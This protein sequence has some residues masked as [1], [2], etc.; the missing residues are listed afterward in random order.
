MTE[1][2]KPSGA[3]PEDDTDAILAELEAE[4]DDTSSTAYQQRLNELQAEA[5]KGS[6]N[7]SF[8]LPETSARQDS[9]LN[10]RSDDETLRFT[11]EHEK[12][13]VHFRHPDFARCSIMDEHLDKIAQRH[14]VGEASGFAKGIVKGK[15]IGFEG[16][17]WNGKEKDSR[18]TKA[19]EERLYEWGLLR[20][21]MLVDEHDTDSGGDDEEERKEGRGIS[22]RRGIR[23]AKQKVTDEDDDW[24]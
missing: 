2:Q 9:Y 11:T 22:V 6:T 1:Q 3:D 19:L 14:N 17:C 4:T 21:K 24:D 16:I 18:V 5:G 15:V 7:G 10:L 20:Q 8:G 13:V 12:A 23:N